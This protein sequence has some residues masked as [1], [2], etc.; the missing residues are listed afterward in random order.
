MNSFSSGSG[1]ILF[2][3]ADE[4][5]RS[6]IQNIWKKNLSYV[7]S[8]AVITLVGIGICFLL[9]YMAG[10][11]LTPSMLFPIVFTIGLVAVLSAAVL[12][13]QLVKVKPDQSFF[14]TVRGTAMDSYIRSTY[15]RSGI[16]KRIEYVNV[17][18]ENGSV[19][20]DIRVFKSANERINTLYS[21]YIFSAGDPVRLLRIN[22]NTVY[23]VRDY[24]S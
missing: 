2:R 24:N 21:G 6:V 3:I 9:I 18:L 14:G 19:A 22:A 11:L 23:A 1:N 15:R 16:R 20:R 12:I 8:R 4:T 13:I 10:G 17:I 7:I 5:D